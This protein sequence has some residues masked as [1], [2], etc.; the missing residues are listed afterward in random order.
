MAEE[1]LNYFLW[2]G[3]EPPSHKIEVLKGEFG[4][5]PPNSP[6]KFIASFGLVGIT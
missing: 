2:L 4:G 3:S 5:E 6:F 1:P